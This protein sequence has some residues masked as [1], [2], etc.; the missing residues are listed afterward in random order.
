M[1]NYET[2]LPQGTCVE[3]K[4]P[5]EDF[6]RTG[7]IWGVASTGAPI[8]GITYIIKP[9]KELGENIYPYKCFVLTEIQFTIIPKVNN[10]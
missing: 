10:D 8:I 3:F 1:E 9:D 6:T 4:L 7:C 2:F 5:E